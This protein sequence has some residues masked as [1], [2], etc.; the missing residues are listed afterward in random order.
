MSTPNYTPIVVNQDS[1]RDTLC[2]MDDY[3]KLSGARIRE[4]RERQGINQAQ[5]AERIGVEPSA[6][7]NYEQGSRYPK[8][9]VLKKMAETLKVPVGWLSG[10]EPDKRIEALSLIY[11]KLDSRGKETVFRVAESQSSAYPDEKA[12]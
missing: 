11:S 1:T 2:G 9:P 12:E 4:A 3:K 6:V 10:L 5:L 8:P 7:G